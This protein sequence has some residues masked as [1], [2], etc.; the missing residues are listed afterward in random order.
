MHVNLIL[1]GGSSDSMNL[2]NQ[3][4]VG[5][6]SYNPKI[7]SIKNGIPVLL[8]YSQL[9]KDINN[10]ERLNKLITELKQ[11]NP[12]DDLELTNDDGSMKISTES[13]FFKSSSIKDSI[14]SNKKNKIPGPGAYDPQKGS[15]QENGINSVSSTFSKSK[16]YQ[17]LLQKDNFLLY[18]TKPE[19]NP[20][21]GLYNPGV[22]VKNKKVKIKPSSQF[23]SKCPRDISFSE[24]KAKIPG[25]GSYSV[26]MKKGNRKKFSKLT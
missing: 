24:K 8:K 13:H 2:V 22:G 26:E 20:P 12:K 25:P 23:S 15:I 3:K 5:P 18:Q 11:L 10:R 7:T 16:K 9:S 14:F 17:D 21:V 6:G 4:N 19:I 1:E